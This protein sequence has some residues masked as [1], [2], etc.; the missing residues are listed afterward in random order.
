VKIGQVD[1]EMIC[2]KLFI[3]LQSLRFSG[4]SSVFSA[5]YPLIICTP[6]TDGD[7]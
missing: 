6:F 1:F 3:L 4:C 7:F 2:L 5:N